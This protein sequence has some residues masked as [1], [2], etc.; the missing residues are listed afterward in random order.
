VVT[1]LLGRPEANL[2]WLLASIAAGI[3]AGSTLLSKM[4]DDDRQYPPLLV[5]GFLGFAAFTVGVAWSRSLPLTVALYVVG[6]F[7]NALI[8]LPIRAWLQT[9]VPRELRGRVFAARGMGLGITGAAAA[10]L[11]GVVVTVWTLPNTLDLLAAVTAAAGVLALI[12]LHPAARAERR[13]VPAETTSA[14]G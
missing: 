4:G 6:G 8:L 12:W 3:W 5:V 11:T 14:R 1:R 10:I 2:G 7:L 9:M 13:R